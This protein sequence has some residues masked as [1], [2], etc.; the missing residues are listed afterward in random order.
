MVNIGKLFDKN[1]LQG[2]LSVVTVVVSVTAALVLLK[3]A[4]LSGH[5]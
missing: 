4:L 2:T 3:V 5:F 1:H